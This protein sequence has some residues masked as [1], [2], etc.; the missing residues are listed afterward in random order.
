MLNVELQRVSKVLNIALRKTNFRKAYK[1]TVF[2]N[3]Q[4]AIRKTQAAKTRANQ[5]LRI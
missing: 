1:V 3:S 5:T 4:I 2:S